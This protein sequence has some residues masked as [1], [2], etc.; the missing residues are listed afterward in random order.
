[1]KSLTILFFWVAAATCL[2]AQSEVVVKSSSE[3]D[4]VVT[5]DVMK[6]GDAERKIKIV[7][8]DDG[9]NK[10]IE[11]T[12]NGEIPEDIQ[13]QLTEYGIDIEMLE[14]GGDEK[15]VMVKVDG[16]DER[17][18]HK[19]VIVIKKS[20]DGETVEYEW[21]GEGE[22][23]AEM[24]EMMK[25]HDIELDMEGHGKGKHKMRKAKM[26]VKKDQMREMRHREHRK[27]RDMKKR[28]KS[29]YKI[30]TINEEGNEHVNVWSDDDH[31]EG[32]H[33]MHGDGEN[34]FIMK[35]SGGN[36]TSKGGSEMHFGGTSR[37]LSDAYI[38]A[39]IESADNG[40]RIVELI[41]DG[42]ADKAGL[43]KGDVIER[44]NGARTRDMDGL[45]TLLNYFEPNDKVEIIVI[46]GDNERK[47]GLT[48]GQ[49]P[50]S[51]R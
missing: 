30:V 44:V 49:R 17:K 4:K 38:G 45:L 26:K 8:N 7:V 32:L 33:E 6:D 25:E 2:F 24:K 12:D 15:R 11:W 21:D 20:D 18:A 50:E 5:V 39:H 40:T 51:M 3:S 16:D 14:G 19:D 41:K 23:P 27:G 9:E 48:L 47:I 13:K 36:W 37:H 34:V 10:T 1:M 28:Q 29:Q 43:Q 22:M 31:G 35:G 46:R 42:P